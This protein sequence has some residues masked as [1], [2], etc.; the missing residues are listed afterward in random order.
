MLAAPYA[1]TMRDHGKAPNGA[2]RAH[3]GHPIE[4]APAITP[5]PGLLTCHFNGG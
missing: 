2:P 1:K 4:K 5:G 3:L